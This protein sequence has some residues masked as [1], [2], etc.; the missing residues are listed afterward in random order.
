MELDQEAIRALLGELPASLGPLRSALARPEGPSERPWL[1]SISS[2]LDKYGILWDE[3]VAALT[4][5]AAGSEV[6]DRMNVLRVL[7]CCPVESAGHLAVPFLSASDPVLPL[8]A[9]DAV[10][11]SGISLAG[12][13]LEV[14]LSHPFELVRFRAAG[15]LG[16]TGDRSTL[17]ALRALFS[18]SGEEPL[19][20]R[21][22]AVSLGDLGGSAERR[23][24][25]EYAVTASNPLVR[26]GIRAGLLRLGAADRPELHPLP[27][28]VHAVQQA[29]RGEAAGIDW[30]LD[31]YE[32]Q[33]LGLAVRF[34][35][36]TIPTSVVAGLTS[37][38]KG[39]SAERRFAAADILGW[40]SVGAASADLRDA[41]TDLDVAV[42]MAASASLMRLGEAS[43]IDAYWLER[44]PPLDRLD[45]ERA[46]AMES[47]VPLGLVRLLLFEPCGL[48]P[49]IGAEIVRRDG[50]VESQ[51]LLDEALAIEWRRLEGETGPRSETENDGFVLSRSRLKRLLKEWAPIRS[52]LPPE[53]QDIALALEEAEI[54]DPHVIAARGLLYG[55][56]GRD[57]ENAAAQLLPW[58]ASRSALLRFDALVLWVAAN[59]SLPAPMHEDV[60]AAVRALWNAIA[61]PA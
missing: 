39:Q 37:W 6:L 8:L 33:R 36:R 46:L 48:L 9:Q 7:A 47:P 28:F 10:A 54:K 52:Q 40:R 18:S 14:L 15:N 35:W 51:A 24:L 22:A 19:V 26:D 29:G 34:A 27:E 11:R 57:P 60:S 20:L 32:D 31:R 53:V 2:D 41:E 17:P 45:A 16:L 3:V 4:P 43:R 61:Q 58:L 44:F 49:R 1:P 23:F 59:G 13:H 21:W 38:L 30:L 56:R 12:E 55:L 5:Y 50:G 25:E 42:C